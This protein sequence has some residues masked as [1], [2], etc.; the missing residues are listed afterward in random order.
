MY[1][2]VF[3][4]R[5]S[6]KKANGNLVKNKTWLREHLVVISGPEFRFSGTGTG[7]SGFYSPE[8]VPTGKNVRPSIRFF[9]L[10]QYM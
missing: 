6:S 4:V 8:N 9:R 3:D 5:V 2:H 10:E 7:I 1:R